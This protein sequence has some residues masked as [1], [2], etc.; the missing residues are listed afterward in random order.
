MIQAQ[1][2]NSHNLLFLKRQKQRVV[3]EVFRSGRYTL[4]KT[5]N[6]HTHLHD[7]FKHR[8]GFFGTD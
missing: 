8:L 3:G 1:A 5:V 4:S 2:G 6:F 7:F